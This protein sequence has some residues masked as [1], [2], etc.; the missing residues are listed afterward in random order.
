LPPPDRTSAVRG[1]VPSSG[2]RLNIA[3]LT[4]AIVLSTICASSLMVMFHFDV[5]D[6]SSYFLLLLA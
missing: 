2:R 3:R 6:T 5:S 1:W 4:L